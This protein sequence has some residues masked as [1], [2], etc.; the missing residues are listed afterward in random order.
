MFRTSKQK[1][2]ENY[3]KNVCLLHKDVSNWS[4][5]GPVQRD[6]HRARHLNQ[7]RACLLPFF[8]INTAT[9]VR[10]KL[11]NE[12]DFAF[13]LLH[14]DVSNWI[15]LVI[16]FITQIACE[17]MTVKSKL[18]TKLV[19][20]HQSPQAYSILRIPMGPLSRPGVSGASEWAWDRR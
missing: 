19:Q 14:K 20:Q 11:S 5:Y 7:K 10:S 15:K 13:C 12:S 16:N 4:E 2:L 8:L 6:S 1:C 17:K 3:F 18:K 9:I